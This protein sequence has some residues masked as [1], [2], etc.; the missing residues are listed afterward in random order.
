MKVTIRDFY[1]DT[2]DRNLSFCDLHTSFLV[3][4]LSLLF[5]CAFCMAPIVNFFVFVDILCAAFN[6]QVHVVFESI[7][8]VVFFKFTMEVVFKLI[9]SGLSNVTDFC[10]F[11]IGGIIENSSPFVQNP[12]LWMYT[13]LGMPNSSLLWSLQLCRYLHERVQLMAGQ[14]R[15]ILIWRTTKNIVPLHEGIVLIPIYT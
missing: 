15:E 7:S 9:I 3:T 10:F 13:F 12:S 1:P 6:L 2:I 11:P 8:L 4:G 5:A 14:N